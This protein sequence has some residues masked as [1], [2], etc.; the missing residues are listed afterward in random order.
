MNYP[1]RN[2]HPVGTEEWHDHQRRATEGLG[3]D[4]ANK[5]TDKR[6]SPVDYTPTPIKIVTICVDQEQG[7]YMAMFANDAMKRAVAGS[8]EAATYGLLVQEKVI[9]VADGDLR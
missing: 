4:Q 9:V 5:I 6:Q 1:M 8:P 3:G 7:R 2:P